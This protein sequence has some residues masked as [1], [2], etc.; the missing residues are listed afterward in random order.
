V[1]DAL[2]RRCAQ[3]LRDRDALAER[4]VRALAPEQVRAHV[5]ALG[6][7][8]RLARRVREGTG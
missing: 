4:E 3:A 7:L 6:Q 8:T 1:D 5:E 2:Y